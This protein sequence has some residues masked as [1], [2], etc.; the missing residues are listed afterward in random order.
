MDVLSIVATTLVGA[1]FV[2]AG[3]SKLAARELW[4]REAAG[5]GAPRWV[6][7]PLP[8][9]ELVIGAAVLVRIAVPVTV[10]AALAVLV[11]FTG[12]IA[13]NMVRGRRPTCACFGAW[14]SSPIGW[15]HVARN[16]VLMGACVVAL[17][18]PA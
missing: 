17:F 3:A 6:V 14:S 7:A 12:A 2:I 15:R 11:V 4:E 18:W 1:A 8:W 5:F 16:V 13:L 9:I 10:G